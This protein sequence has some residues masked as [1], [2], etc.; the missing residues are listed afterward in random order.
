M[1]APS[2]GGNSVCRPLGSVILAT[3]WLLA[4]NIYEGW[5]AV[6][7]KAV[8]VLRG[9]SESSGKCAWVSAGKS[10]WSVSTW[11][12]GLMIGVGVDCVHVHGSRGQGWQCACGGGG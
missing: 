1:A 3:G 6:V 5:S 2:S 7:V 9:T 11:Q 4:A 12:L 10:Q 8:G